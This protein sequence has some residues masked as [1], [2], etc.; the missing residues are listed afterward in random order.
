MAYTV[1]STRA[2]SK[3]DMLHNDACPQITVNAQTHEVHADGE[4]LMCE[5]ATEVALGQR[6]FLR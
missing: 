4:L 5:P 3:R 2:L 1:G 6:Y